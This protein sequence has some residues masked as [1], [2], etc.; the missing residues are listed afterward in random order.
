MLPFRNR[1]KKQ[2]DFESIF[3][4]GRGFSEGSLYL[5]VN[6]N[7]LKSSRFG[8]VVSKKF[9]KK[10]VDR[11]RIKRILREI[12]KEKIDQTKKGLDVAIIVN[13][14]AEANYQELKKTIYKLFKKS[15]LLSS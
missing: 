10:A 14:G 15:K 8:F 7:D 13:P 3:K 4:N 2:K 5:K 11:N 9:S 12:V 1:L 6:K